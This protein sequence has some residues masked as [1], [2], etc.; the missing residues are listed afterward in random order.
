MEHYK[1][2]LNLFSDFVTAG[3]A[4]KHA[5]AFESVADKNSNKKEII[6]ELKKK[7]AALYAEYK[8][9]PEAVKAPEVEEKI[10]SVLKL[11]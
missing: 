6:K 2:Y 9:L 10:L 8:Q 11:K 1:R 3:I 5:L 7:A 4:Y